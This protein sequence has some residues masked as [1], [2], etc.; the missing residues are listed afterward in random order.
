MTPQ[1]QAATREALVLLTHTFRMEWANYRA[2][3]TYRA[4]FHRHA[5][6]VIATIRALREACRVNRIIG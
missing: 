6:R 4:D 5:R 1:Q 2:H 3:A